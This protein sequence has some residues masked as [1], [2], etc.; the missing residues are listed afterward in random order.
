MRPLR[1]ACIVAFALSAGCSGSSTPGPPAATAA[2][3][4]QPV[5]LLIDWQAEP[6]YLGIYYAKTLGEYRNVGYD[7]KVIQSWGANEAASSIAAGAYKFGTASGGATVIANS[8]G[9]DL[10]S[11]GVLYHRL[12]TSVFG[13]ASSG[14]KSP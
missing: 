2:A 10:V 8:K 7:V 5:E 1:F 13:L 14:I 11:T 12:P 9:A 4:T 6:T 3:E